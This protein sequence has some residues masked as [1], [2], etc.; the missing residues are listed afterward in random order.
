V[1]IGCCGKH[2][3]DVVLNVAED[4]TES[5]WSTGL[6]GDRLYLDTLYKRLLNSTRGVIEDCGKRPLVDAS[7][8]YLRVVRHF[9]KLQLVE[10]L[11]SSTVMRVV[12]DA[13]GSKSLGQDICNFW[14]S[15]A[16][17]WVPGDA[18]TRL[19]KSSINLDWD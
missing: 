10:S 15:G 1:C 19:E 9:E 17:A 18:L 14:S 5:L 2:G 4:H 3:L 8:G 12:E 16:K 6:G 13:V 11:Y 7:C